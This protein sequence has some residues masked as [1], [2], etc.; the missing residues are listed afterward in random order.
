MERGKREEETTNHGPEG[1]KASRAVR[2]ARGRRD[3]DCVLRRGRDIIRRMSAWTRAVWLRTA[4]LGS[5]LCAGRLVWAAEGDAMR[6]PWPAREAVPPA[7]DSLARQY[8]R[9]WLFFYQ[10]CLTSVTASRC[11]MIPSCSNYSLEAIRKH[12]AIMGILLTADRLL[13]EWEEQR[14]VPLVR[15]Q[16]RVGRWD[17]VEA[18]DFWWAP[19]DKKTVYDKRDRP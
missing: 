2:C 12:G 6:G 19:R 4:I 5:F 11:P 18:N 9:G 17:P 14:H 1:H 15:R 7:Q 13:H 8:C 3:R 16:G 10:R